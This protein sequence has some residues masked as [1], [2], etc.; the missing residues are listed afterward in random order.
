MDNTK[1]A[2]TAFATFSPYKSTWSRWYSWGSLVGAWTQ[3]NTARG[4][5]FLHTAQF[6]RLTPRHLELIGIKH[7]ALRAG[8]LLFLSAYNGDP[9]V[10]FRGF[11]DQL[12][13]AMNAVWKACRDWE[14]AKPFEKLD[15][16][17]RTYRRPVGSFFN[18]YPDTAKRIR[19][20]LVLRRQIDKLTVLATMPA[21]TPNQL[22]LADARF[23]VALERV[24][25]TQWSNVRPTKEDL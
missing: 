16:F 1:G 15:K 2:T 4:P 13:V 14:A 17:I 18:A 23:A 12:F 3:T 21:E 20:M 22:A 19:S 24:V 9:E 25:H 8:G 5:E 7:E 6:V 10:Y 11:S